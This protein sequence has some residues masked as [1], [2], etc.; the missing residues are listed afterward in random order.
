MCKRSLDQKW[1]KND[2]KRILPLSGLFLYLIAKMYLETLP[3][4]EFSWATLVLHRQNHAIS[5]LDKTSN[6]VWRKKKFFLVLEEVEVKKSFF[7]HSNHYATKYG[8]N[9]VFF[10]VRPTLGSNKLQISIPK[11]LLLLLQEKCI[12]Y[13]YIYL[14][15]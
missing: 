10:L 13:R 6:L 12:Y 14:Y 5:G 4:L 15:Y 2:F 9:E 3:R 1:K 8:P 7:Q 11:Y